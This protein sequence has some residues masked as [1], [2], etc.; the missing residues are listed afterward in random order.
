MVFLSIIEMTTEYENQHV[1][2][3]NPKLPLKKIWQY[4]FAGMR[5]TRKASKNI[6]CTNNSEG[7]FFTIDFV[8]NGILPRKL[9]SILCLMTPHLAYRVESC[10]M[11]QGVDLSLRIRI[12]RYIGIL[13]TFIFRVRCRQRG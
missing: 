6:C 13:K 3:R 8:L 2:Q 5:Q 11:I 4:S 7:E 9:H 10:L 12:S 1:K